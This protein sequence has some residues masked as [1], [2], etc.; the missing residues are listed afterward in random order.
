MENWSFLYFVIKRCS[1][2]V[3]GR[4]YVHFHENDTVVAAKSPRCTLHYE[5]VLVISRSPFSTQESGPEKRMKQTVVRIKFVLIFFPIVSFI[6]NVLGTFHLSITIPRPTAPRI[7]SH[8]LLQLPLMFITLGVVMVEDV[9]M[10]YD[11]TWMLH[12]SCRSFVNNLSTWM[13]TLA[14]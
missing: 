14:N 12:L 1:T 5:H 8:T 7:L 6:P 13:S 10:G 3:R 9:G 11:S 4:C 2:F